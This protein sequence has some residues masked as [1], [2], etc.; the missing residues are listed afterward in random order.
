MGTVLDIVLLAALLFFVISGFRR[1]LVRSLVELAGCIAAIYCSAVFS[2]QFAA[3]ALPYVKQWFPTWPSGLLLNR[4]IASIVLFAVF[5]ALTQAVALLMD[6]VCHLPVLRQVNALLGG[7]F[8]LLKGGAV[9]LM[10][11]AVIQIFTPAAK[12]EKSDPLL[13][14]LGG[15]SAFQYAYTHNPVYKLFQ[16]DFLNGIGVNN[17]RQK[18]E[19]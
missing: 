14:K 6:H 4:A 17:E 10:A 11:L 19:L 18:Q 15:Y 3:A 2:A 1:G 16:E 12:I 9:L 7:V 8:G 13:Q 5:E